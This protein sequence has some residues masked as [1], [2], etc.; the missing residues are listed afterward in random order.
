MASLY[1]R[2]SRTVLLVHGILL[3]LVVAAGFLPSCPR[4]EDPLAA[5]APPPPPPPTEQRAQLERERSELEELERDRPS[6]SLEI[7]PEALLLLPRSSLLADRPLPPPPKAQPQPEPEPK[8]E[9][10][11]EPEPEPEPEPPPPAERISFEEFK[12]EH[13]EP[14][15]TRRPPPPPP[16][17]EVP[18]F[19]VSTDAFAGLLAPAERAHA[20]Q[21]GAGQQAALL[22]FARALRARLNSAWNRPPSLANRPLEATVRFQVAPDGT[23]QGVRIT[24][25]SGVALFDSSVRQAFRQVGKVDPPPG[26]QARLYEIPFRNIL[27]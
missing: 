1:T 27:D 20:S 25:S 26:R 10:Q 11:P 8:P 16:T 13:G 24:R 17:V 19:S 22:S 4:R 18:D 9:P 23:L 12:R 21:L 6:P 7:N 15:P 3:L 14:E 5:Q 2:T